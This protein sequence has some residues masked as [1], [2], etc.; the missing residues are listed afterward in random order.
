MSFWSRIWPRQVEQRGVGDEAIEELLRRK[1]S[2]EDADAAAAATVEAAT[3]L[4]ARGL[5]LGEWDPARLRLPSSDVLSTI[6]R[7]LV[8]HGESLWLIGG[9]GSALLPVTGA[10]VTGGPDPA[11]WLYDLDL[12]APTR[13][14]RRVR[15]QADRVFHPRWHV[16]RETPWVG[17][18]PLTA[19]AS[20]SRL[21]ARL[22][23]SL[24]DES[25]TATGQVVPIPKGPEGQNLTAMTEGLAALRGRLSLIETTSAGWGDGRSAAPQ[26]DWMPRRLGPAWDSPLEETRMRAALE[27]MAA[28]GVPPGL[29]L[30]EAS[31]GQ[32]EA[33]RTW[34]HTGLL[35]MARVVEAEVEAKLGTTSRLRFPRLGAADVTGKARALGSL[36]TAGVPL[37]EARQVVGL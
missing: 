14:A 25:G 4:Y 24:G 26:G 17:R 9:G 10:T 7:D 16:D 21:L 35:P 5:L 28:L 3:G 18:S 37:D 19:A 23:R 6:A 27:V 20:T 8:L 30:G 22:E 33:L 12:P 2:D 36:V 1:T 15:V 29:L 31:T 11:S 32:R 34:Y 13:T